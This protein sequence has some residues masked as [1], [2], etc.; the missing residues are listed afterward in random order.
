MLNQQQHQAVHFVDE[1]CL[2]LAG[3]GSGKTRVI[4]E[5][6]KFLIQSQY[7][8]PDKIYALTFTNKAAK[9]MQTRLGKML[10]PTATK[11]GMNEQQSKPFIGTFHKLGIK[12]L[13]E[14]ANLIGRKKYF[15]ILDDTDSNKLI[16]DLLPG[17]RSDDPLI[18]QYRWKI[19]EWKSSLLRP[20]E[21]LKDTKDDLE[22]STALIYKEYQELLLQHQSFDFDDLITEVVYLFTDN[23][24]IREEWAHRI[25]YVL[26]DECQD[27]NTA[28]YR[29]LR[30][31][32]AH[33]QAFTVVGDDD[34]SIYAWRGAQPENLLNLQNDY[35][36]LK[37][38]KLEQN[39]RSTNRI[40][41]AANHLIKN[42]QHIFEKHLWSDQGLGEKIM[43]N[44][45]RDAEDEGMLVINQIQRINIK[46]GKFEEMA[47][48]YRSNHQARE[49]ER[50]LRQFNIPYNISGGISFFDRTEIRDIIAYL[51]VIANPDDSSA[52]LRI[53]NT[54][55]RQ[56]GK[57]TLEALHQVAKTERCSLYQACK[58]PSLNH[59]L[60][61][62]AK[63]K[64][65]AFIYLLDSLHELS[66]S[67]Q[68]LSCI[69]ELMQNTAYLDWI[70]NQAK[71]PEEAQAKQDLVKEL[72]EWVGRILNKESCET[73]SDVLTHLALVNNLE[74]EEQDTTGQVQLMTLHAA[75]G[76][77]FPFVF[78]VGVEEGILPH[79]NSIDNGD[80]EEERRLAYVGITRA[81][82]ELRISYARQRRRFKD[83]YD[84]TPSRFL[85]ELPEDCIQWLGRSNMSED[86][87]KEVTAN[88]FD[89]IEALLAG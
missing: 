85:E 27:T 42:N 12:I 11:L 15:S 63:Q 65:S 69:D 89:D 79:Q 9:E 47:I 67:G 30:L 24:D 44:P 68:V 2:V 18:R 1:P 8:L 5:K 38:I 78:L 26:V 77:E 40:L 62:S 37:V 64:L 82:S 20:H 73:L 6:I 35:P 84:C 88:I 71:S 55:R 25:R 72:I 75:K 70:Q 81:K 51:R 13:R 61:N 60:N 57:T 59:S 83:T 23:P 10:K 36:T 53:I 33:N 21:V 87:K 52:L 39:Y 22:R 56:I 17:V 16:Q 58:H 86:E 54:P 32:L 46:G 31:L 28:Q 29:L 7:C 41:Q 19:S 34:Q 74:N 3:A 50:Q 48:L 66:N 45:A 14:N 4:T 80:I 76:L 43:I 49:F